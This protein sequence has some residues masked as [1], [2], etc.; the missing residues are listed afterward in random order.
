ML[1]NCSTFRDKPKKF[2]YTTA[3]ALS[4]S[5]LPNSSKAATELDNGNSYGP[6][7]DL[8]GFTESS[9]GTTDVTFTTNEGQFLGLSNKNSQRNFFIN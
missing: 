5:I 7:D 8:N 6:T 9:Y 3:L 1:N 4:L 2:L